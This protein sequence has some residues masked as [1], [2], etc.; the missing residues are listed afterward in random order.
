[1]TAKIGFLL[2][3]AVISTVSALRCFEGTV[4]LDSNDQTSKKECGGMSN[5]CIQRID[6]KTKEM[7]RECSSWS[8]E[9]SMEEKC[10]MTGC[11][12]QTKDSTFCCCQ[13]DECNEWKGDGTEFK[14]GETSSKSKAVPS[15]P[16][17]GDVIMPTAATQK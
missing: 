15:A 14:A 6:K 2:I 10:P 12:F 17:L 13:F 11:H 4:A 7:R 9:H 3:L 16:K 8:D 5:Y 1:M